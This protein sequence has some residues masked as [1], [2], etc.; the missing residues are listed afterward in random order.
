MDAHINAD[1]QEVVINNSTIVLCPNCNTFIEKTDVPSEECNHVKCPYCSVAICYR[2]V[3]VRSVRG[4][5]TLS[6]ENTFKIEKGRYYAPYFWDYRMR[7]INKSVP[8]CSQRCNEVHNMHHQLQIKDGILTRVV[9]CDKIDILL[10]S[11]SAKNYSTQEQLADMGM[12][13]EE[14]EQLR[15]HQEMLDHHRNLFIGDLVF[16]PFIRENRQ[17]ILNRHMRA[18]LNR[19]SPLFH[20]NQD[21]PSNDN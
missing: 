11:Q 8:V 15:Q 5:S 12:S 4:E 10:K 2:C 17:S 14:I 21:T 9:C 6:P 7:K 16:E 20:P 19:L 1:K 18:I 3:G 13:A